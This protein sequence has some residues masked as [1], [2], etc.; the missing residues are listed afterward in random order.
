[1]FLFPSHLSAIHLPSRGSTTWRFPTFTLPRVFLL[2][3]FGSVL[4]ISAAFQT[5]GVDTLSPKKREKIN[6]FQDPSDRGMDV[7]KAV[8]FVALVPNER[9]APSSASNGRLAIC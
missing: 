3:L 5:V 4:P 9:Y 2:L 1:M 7:G 8:T 6:A